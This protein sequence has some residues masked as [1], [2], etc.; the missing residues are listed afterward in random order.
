MS[1][2]ACLSPLKESRCFVLFLFVQ[3]LTTFLATHGG[4]TPVN[5]CSDPNLP[6][7]FAIPPPINTLMTWHPYQIY[8]LRSV[9]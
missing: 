6:Y 2:F 3:S 7:W 9:P 1:T 5:G 8:S 4:S